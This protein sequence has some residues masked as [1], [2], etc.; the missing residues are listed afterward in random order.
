MNHGALVEWIRIDAATATF[1]MTSSSAYAPNE[2]GGA[3]IGYVEGAGLHIVVATPPGPG[4]QHHPT[5][6]MRDGS[7][8]QK[9]LDEAF[10]ASNG[11][12]DYVGEWHS[13]PFSQGPSAKDRASMRRIAS[14]SAYKSL[15]PVMILCRRY[16]RSWRLDAFQWDGFLLAPRALEITNDAPNPRDESTAHVPSRD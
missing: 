15:H 3:L 14:R 2:T 7:F 9:L 16:R 5:L 13:H 10:A 11:R 6:F 4:A 12:H 8:S 1:M